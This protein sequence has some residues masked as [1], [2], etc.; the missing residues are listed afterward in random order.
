M[1]SAVPSR[2]G[3]AKIS[4]RYCYIYWWAELFCQPEMHVSLLNSFSSQNRNLDSF[5]KKQNFTTSLACNQNFCQFL[6]GSWSKHVVF[7][8][9][10]HLTTTKTFLQVRIVQRNRSTRFARG[11]WIQQITANQK[12]SNKAKQKLKLQVSWF[13][14]NNWKNYAVFNSKKSR[15]RKLKFLKMEILISL[16]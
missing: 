7:V 3:I 10:K 5:F 8:R 16:K 12:S 2:V 6:C 9:I 14:E 13:S 15:K 4:W 1:R 11:I